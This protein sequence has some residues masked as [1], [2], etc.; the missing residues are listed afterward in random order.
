VKTSHLVG[1]GS[2]N[3]AEARRQGDLNKANALIAEEITF[4]DNYRVRSLGGQIA[5]KAAEA[6]VRRLTPK[7]PEPK[8]GPATAANANAT[9]TVAVAVAAEPAAVEAPRTQTAENAAVAKAPDPSWLATVKWLT[10]LFL[11]LVFLVWVFILGVLVGRGS[12]WDNTNDPNASIAG[13]RQPTVTVVTEPAPAEPKAAPSNQRLA[14]GISPKAAA[15]PSAPLLAPSA[16]GELSPAKFALAAENS[17]PEEFSFASEPLP[18]PEL[19][20]ESEL[21]SEFESELESQPT[22][23]L[24]SE[25]ES[26]PA[27][28]PA[29]TPAPREP[30]REATP[31]PAPQVAEA[32]AYWPAQPEGQGFYTV[33]I[34]AAKSAEE[35]KRIA[36]NFQ[37]RNFGAYYYE[38][39]PKHFP[40]RVGRYKTEGEAEAAK[41]ILAKAGAAAPYVS[42]LNQN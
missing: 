38:K 25:L 31:K 29:A 18:E 12:L 20:L 33:Q 36:E 30:A 27:T 14:Q 21:E 19:A 26:E 22:A 37:K 34:A 35:A 17:A 8:T 13:A 42:R 1:L 3:R 6:A 7:P 10:R 2:P 15:P 16:Q 11:S 41:K 5:E 4:F 9:A 39:S 28:V 40:V 32:T 24:A 23:E